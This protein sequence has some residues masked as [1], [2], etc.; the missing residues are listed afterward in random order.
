MGVA[1][2]IEPRA[3]ETWASK[4]HGPINFQLLAIYFMLTS[5]A[6][7]NLLKAVIV[8]KK[9]GLFEEE[10]A[11]K[12]QLPGRLKSH[13]LVALAKEA[14]MSSIFPAERRGHS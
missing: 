10:L 14:D 1:E 6:I 5:Y 3:L 7:E 9:K 4:G 13:D 8:Q 11:K 12:A 2:L